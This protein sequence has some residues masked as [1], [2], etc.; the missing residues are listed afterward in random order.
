MIRR[1]THVPVRASFEHISASLI[2]GGNTPGVSSTYTL[3]WLAI[4]SLLEILI[5]S[6]ST[7]ESQK[8]RHFLFGHGKERLQTSRKLSLH[9]NGQEHVFQQKGFYGSTNSYVN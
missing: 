3:G 6:T 4:Y 9:S 5:R 7:K 2:I 1:A 8:E